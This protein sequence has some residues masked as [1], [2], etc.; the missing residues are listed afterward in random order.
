MPQ[1]AEISGTVAVPP[2]VYNV[3]RSTGHPL[4]E[5]TRA[6]F[7]TRF[8]HDFSRVRIHTDTR[9]GESAQAVSALAFTV[10]QDLVFGPG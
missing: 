8:G 5:G 2:I 9:A 7:G 10:G 4:D 6:F 1:R 3:L